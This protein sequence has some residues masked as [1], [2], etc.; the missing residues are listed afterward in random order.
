[1]TSTKCAIAAAAL[2]PLEDF[3]KMFPSTEEYQSMSTWIENSGKKT[4]PKA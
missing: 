4:N 2:L 1:M 3:E